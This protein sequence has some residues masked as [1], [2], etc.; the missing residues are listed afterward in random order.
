M[1][2][3]KGAS[4]FDITASMTERVLS[5]PMKSAI[6]G[7]LTAAGAAASSIIPVKFSIPHKREMK[8]AKGQKNANENTG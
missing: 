3:N 1:K 8:R 2:Y 6:T 5:A 7:E 4:R